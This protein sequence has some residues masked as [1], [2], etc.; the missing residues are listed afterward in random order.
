[1]EEKRTELLKTE[2]DLREIEE[3]YYSSS[4]LIHDKLVEDLRVNTKKMFLPLFSWTRPLPT[5]IVS[6]AHPHVLVVCKILA[7]GVILSI[8][9]LLVLLVFFNKNRLN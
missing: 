2:T 9:L 6:F 5:V 8:K 4:A 7:P 1:M 3:K